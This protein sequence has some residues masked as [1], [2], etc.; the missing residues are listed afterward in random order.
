MIAPTLLVGLGGTGSKIVCRV[1]KMVTEEQRQRIGFAVFDTDINELRE[2]REANPFIKTIQTS[3]KLSVGEYLNIDTHARDTWFPVNAILNSKTLT[4]GAGQV[5]AISRLALDTAIRAG[6]M[7]PLHQAIEDLYKL[8]EEQSDQALR[9]IIVSSLAGG[10]GSGLILPVA[11]YIKNFLSTRFQQ[12][13]NITRG[14]FILPEVFYEVIRGQAERNNLKC[15]AYATLRE[16]DAFLMKGD[17]TLPDKYAD[18]VKLEFPRVGSAEFEEYNVRPYDFCFLFDAQNTEGKK[19]NDFNQY[20]D[21]AANCIYSQSIGPMNK[22]SN[23]SEDNTIRELC[24]EQ[25][26]NRYAGAGSSMLIYPVEDVKEYIALKWTQECV[27]DQWLVFDRMYKEKCINNSEMR[28]QGYA[29]KDANPSTDYIES[30]DQMAKQKNP[31]AMSIVNQCTIFDESGLTKEGVRWE[32][33][34]ANLKKFVENNASSGQT[35]LDSQKQN[36]KLGIDEIKGG[37]EVWAEFQDAFREMDK[38]RAMVTKRCEDTARTIAYAIFKAKND[39]ITKEKHNYQLETYL[40]DG[41]GK[42]IHP[43]AV[44]FFL[45]QAFELLKSEKKRVDKKIRDVEKFFEDFKNIF[46]DPKTEDEEGIDQL[47]DRRISVANKLGKMTGDQQDMKQ[48]FYTYMN[49]VDEYRVNG[50]LASVLEEGISY[51]SSLCDAFQSFYLSFESK[52]NNI[53]RRISVI[54]KKYNHTSGKTARYV[55]ASKECLEKLVEKMPY[56]GSAVAIDGDLADDIYSK[57]RNYSMLKDKPDNNGYF[58]AIFENGIIGYFKNKLMQTYGD[59]VNMDIITAL[60]KEVELE[61]GECDPAK[62]EI[63]VKHVIDETRKLSNPFIERPLGEQKSPISACAYNNKLDPHD[64]SPKSDLISKELKN[65]G[66]TAD[67]D[68]PL[69]MIMFYQSIYGLRANRL[70][71]FTPADESG[72][73]EGEYFK[74]YYELVNKIKPKSD[75]TP[76]ITPHIDRNWHIISAIPDLD[77]NNQRAQENRIY[78]AFMLG[79]IF[80]MIKYSKIS[81]GK[82]LYRLEIK[83]C[84]AEEFVVSNRT[85]CDNFYEVLDALTINP[86]IVNCILNSAKRIFEKEINGTGKVS[87]E[88]SKMKS[89]LDTLTLGEFKKSDVTLFDLATLL[90][91]STPS[92]NFDKNLGADIMKVMLDSV[93]EYMKLMTLENELDNVYGNFVVDQYKKFDVNIDWYLD[94]WKDNFSEYI[95]DM[96]RVASESLEDRDLDDLCEVIRLHRKAATEKRG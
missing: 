15:N 58:N 57:V 35:D 30:I 55:C 77:D 43:N 63:Y 4:E 20:L 6:N 24:A 26:R 76:V 21:H 11:M 31:F 85:P 79:L 5:R 29:V 87:F 60:E 36:A 1:S 64:D 73:G 37:T 69:G 46:D 16:L 86:V 44:R 82:Y 65:Y 39:S 71:K 7:E 50:I 19:L 53:K 45:Y 67:E 89:R 51:V 12:S 33:Y 78:S 3:T 52:I 56:T 23:S 48:S 92:A 9:V 72:R 83:G 22:R 81:E 8:E 49:K 66:G 59:D 96:I 90:K 10:T 17:A 93:Y 18:S 70:S 28:S 74:A 95:D 13:A 91:V 47:A 80:D 94:N 40:R 41:E 61:Q 32:M 25:G 42:F 27:S 14:F 84:K 54:S 34:V 62:V 2:I 38:Y 75:K 68:I 88:T